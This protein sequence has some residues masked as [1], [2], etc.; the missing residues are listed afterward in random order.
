MFLFISAILGLRD[1]RELPFDESVDAEEFETCV[2]L[3]FED[4]QVF[5]ELSFVIHGYSLWCISFKHSNPYHF[6]NGSYPQLLR[7][8]GVVGCRE[9]R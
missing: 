6:V 1:F 7:D 9:D 4:W 5:D 2:P 3:Q 8:E